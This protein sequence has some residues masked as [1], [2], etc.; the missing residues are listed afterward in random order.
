MDL[1]YVYT[2]LE[3]ICNCNGNWNRFNI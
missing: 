3:L 1:C 2:F